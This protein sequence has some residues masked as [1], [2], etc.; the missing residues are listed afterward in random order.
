MA[1]GAL[2]KLTIIPFKDA[3]NVQVPIPS[4]PPFVCPFNPESLS[5]STTYKYKE[6]QEHGKDG[7]EAKFEG[8]EPRTFSFDIFLDGTGASGASLEVMPLIELFKT[9]VGFQGDIHRP[10]F[11]IVSWGTFFVRCVLVNY[12]INYKLFRPSGLPLRAVIS[13]SWKEYKPITLGSLIDNLLSPD[14]THLH[15]VKESEHLSLITYG[16][17]K[18]PKYY[19]QVAEKNELNNLRKVNPGVVLQLYPLK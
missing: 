14:V 12:S 6:D 8:I 3:E 16:V 1:D 13:T 4:G 10:N 18:D 17:Y 7:S 5:I 9:T 11:F 2:V 15:T 19:L